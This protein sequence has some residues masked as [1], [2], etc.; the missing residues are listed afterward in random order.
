MIATCSSTKLQI[1]S[2][3]LSHVLSRD[4]LR[5]VLL[6]A[7]KTLAIDATRPNPI[8]RQRTSFSRSGTWILKINVSGMREKKKSLTVKQTDVERAAAHDLLG[9]T[10]LRSRLGSSIKSQPE[11]KGLHEVS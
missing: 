7:L 5:M 9:S 3:T 11:L 10:Q 4:R 1:T 8:M 6:T 2:G